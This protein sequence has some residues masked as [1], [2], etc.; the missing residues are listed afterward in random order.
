[1]LSSFLL[2]YHN[3][4]L[5]SF[6]C[7]DVGDAA[8]AK[9]K[10]IREWTLDK[11]ILVVHCFID[12]EGVPP[13]TPQGGE[14]LRGLLEGARVGRVSGVEARIR[15]SMRIVRLRYEDIGA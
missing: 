11:E 14:R 3:F 13:V 10:D 15:G 5:W 1:M 4:P 9:A 12:L 7:G 6:V 2:D 8:V